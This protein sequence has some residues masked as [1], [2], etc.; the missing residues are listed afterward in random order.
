VFKSRTNVALLE[1]QDQSSRLK[2]EADALQRKYDLVRKCGRRP[3][4]C[5]AKY[6]LCGRRP[7]R[8][9]TNITW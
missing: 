3:K 6:D 5:S 9:S 2:E 4:R 8:C 7:T 1:A